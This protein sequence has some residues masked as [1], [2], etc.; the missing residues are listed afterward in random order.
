MASP[1]HDLQST[2]NNAA[3]PAGNQHVHSAATPADD[4]HAATTETSLLKQA[5]SSVEPLTGAQQTVDAIDDFYRRTDEIYH[6]LAR[7]LG[8]SDSSFD[9]LY[10]LTLH[11]GLTQKGLCDAA[12]SSKQTVHSA[13]KKLEAEGFIEFKGSTPRN[14][15]AYLTERGRTLSASHIAPVIEAERE[16]A[17][18]LTP[19]EQARFQN[20]MEH[21]TKALELAFDKLTLPPRNIP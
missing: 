5:D 19:E 9:I 7:R 4:Q 10:A 3:T 2:T 20:A 1:L 6:H 14:R 18:T 12:F 15:C 16:A 21:Y 17:L 8:L 11:D 13:V